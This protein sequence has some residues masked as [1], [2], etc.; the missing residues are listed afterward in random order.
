MILARARARA[1]LAELK[2]VLSAIPFRRLDT[3]LSGV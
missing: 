3:R 1:F 2:I